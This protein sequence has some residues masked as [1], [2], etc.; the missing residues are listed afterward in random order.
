MYSIGL[1]Y[2]ISCKGG[3]VKNRCNIDYVSSKLPQLMLSEFSQFSTSCVNSYN[4]FMLSRYSYI[5]KLS[6]SNGKIKYDCFVGI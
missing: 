1:M 4:Y 2:Y 6:L 3:N 5:D